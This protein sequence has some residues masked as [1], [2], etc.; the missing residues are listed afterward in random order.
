[1][2]SYMI[3]NSRWPV[4]TTL[5]VLV[6]PHLMAS[7]SLSP[8]RGASPD[9]SQEA[10]VVEES[11]TTWRFENDG[12]GRLDRYLRVKVQSEAGVVMWGQLAFPYNS[13]NERMDVVFVRVLSPDGTVV[14]APANAVQDLS[15][16]VQR[17]APVYTDTREKHITVPGLRPGQ[18]V[19]LALTIVMHTPL[20]LG[21]FWAEHEF[22]GTG[23]VLDDRLQLD[24]PRD[25]A[26]TLKTRSGL[27]QMVTEREGRRLYEWRTSRLANDESAAKSARDIVR[28]LRKP[29]PAAVRVTTFASWEELGQWFG[30]LERS[31][32]AP[33]AEIRKKAKEL[34]ANRAT[35]MSKLEALYEYVATDFRYVSLSFGVGR[36]QPHAAGDVLRNQYGDCKDKHTLLAS[37]AESIGLHA[38][39]VLMHSAR[40]IDPDFPSP[41]QFDHV[42]T[43]VTVGSDVAWLDATTEVAPFRLLAPTLRKKR[44]LVVNPDGAA[45][46][47]ESPAATPMLNVTT[48]DI[49]ATLTESGTLAAHVRL[50]FASDYELVMRT[51]REKLVALAGS[52]ERAAA[53][54]RQC[55]DQ[56]QRNRMISLE[57]A[58]PAGSTADF[59]VLL[60][61]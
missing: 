10:Y 9:Y 54:E 22:I 32:R 29:E 2:N 56:L 24:V 28:K 34:T 7:Q 11:R 33:T 60:A 19:E 39:P 47:E 42:I 57:V 18:V 23:I 13:A 17:E 58:G 49:D 45:R 40:T 20:A 52:A 15:S 31:Q 55:G 1:V 53:A 12:T 61:N 26:I 44:S 8:A 41:S 48:A 5:V 4:I 43:R 3:K 21:H 35:E 36:Y 38:S 6:A 50:T 14:A 25:R 37:L 59:Y 30:D 51:T 46:L 16:A 27:D